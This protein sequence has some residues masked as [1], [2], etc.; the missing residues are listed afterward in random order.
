MSY[1]NL[2]GSGTRCQNTAT[3]VYGFIFDSEGILSLSHVYYFLNLAAAS[4]DEAALTTLSGIMWVDP[5]R[6]ARRQAGVV[7]VAMPR[8]FTDFG[9]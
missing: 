4:P 1:R 8:H 7:P 6:Q 3:A 5:R 2:T 9:S